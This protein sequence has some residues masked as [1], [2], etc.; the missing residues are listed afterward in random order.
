MSS[1]EL[2]HVKHCK[3]SHEVWNKLKEV[4]ESKG[5]A[6]KATLLKQL[7]FTKMSRSEDMSDHLNNFFS[8][9][10]KLKEMDIVV[11]DD[12]LSVLLLYGTPNTY[13]NFKCAIELRD[14]LPTP[15]ALKIKLLE[16][17]NSRHNS[18][19]VYDHQEALQVEDL[20][21]HTRAHQCLKKKRDNHKAEQAQVPGIS[22]TEKCLR[23]SNI[24][25]EDNQDSIITVY[26]HVSLN[27]NREP[28]MEWCID[29]DATSHIC[30]DISRFESIQP[31]KNQKSKREINEWQKPA[32][33][34]GTAVLFNCIKNKLWNFVQFQLENKLHVPILK[35]NLILVSKVAP[36]EKRFLFTNQMATIFEK[37]DE[38]YIQANITT[39]LKLF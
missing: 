21:K 34:K 4:Y 35:A 26:Y 28:L 13:E 7:L 29:S 38:K 6:R 22:K 19:A 37:N 20:N 14:Q 1:S 33:I 9:A 30:C 32:E 17:A 3:T 2:C 12:L 16:E 36:T 10:D 39:H 31:I 25:Y 24:Q 8:H 27:I 11:A 5:P 23:A 15:D 18:N